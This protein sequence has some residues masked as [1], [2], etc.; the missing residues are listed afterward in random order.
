M[1]DPSLERL[2]EKLGSVLD[3]RAA[4]ALLHWDQE[5]NMPPKGA[6]SRGRQLAT[7]SAT[8]HDMFTDAQ[9]GELL[10]RLA[11]DASLDTDD[12]RLVA[13]AKYDYERAT[14]LPTEFVELFARERSDAYE[15]WVKARKD[16]KFITF[17]PHLERLVD[18]LRQKADLLGYQGTPYNALIEDYERGMTAEHLERVFGDL[19]PKQSALL[20][21]IMASPNQPDTAWTEREWNA[22]AQWAFTLRVLRDIGYDF[23]AGRQD[24]SVHPFTT[25][26]G[27]YDVR[28]TTRVDPRD[29]FAALTGSL[30]E[31]GHALYE[32]GFLA[33][34]ER[35]LL[36]SAASLGIHE[37]QSRL[38][39]NIIGRSLPFWRHYAKDF[40]AGFQVA[41]DADSVAKIY[42]AVNAVRPSYI[43]VEADE[44]TYNLHV[45][46]RFEIEKALI[47]GTLA[48]RDVPEA[49]NA[50][51]K[52][53][54]GLDVPDDARGCLQDVH[55]S[56]GLMGYFPTYALGNMYSAQL[57]EQI[58]SDV[59]GVWSS[60]ERGEFQLLL[61]WLREHVH[62]HGRRK[63]AP[64]IV[65]DATGRPPESGPYLRYL[66]TKYGALYGI[67]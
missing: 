47:E 50:K 11:D 43:R 9:T 10:A 16:S 59:P 38:W 66:E 41:A 35:S 44:C 29:P 27:L 61:A 42:R 58:E 34:D 28:V 5:V 23:E 62:R 30:H 65:Q 46:L 26:F 13:E 2:R 60:I 32:Q 48:V 40:L 45:F 3:V 55:W 51:F 4:I 14:R 18:L 53:Y 54:L 52:R 56:E 1:T 39:E 12:A 63:T 17:R 20:E 8:E 57:F 6:A 49:W 24:R 21:R 25:N 64:E 36:G 67:T 33:Q 31:G 37:S 7:L 19:A 15:A 22:D